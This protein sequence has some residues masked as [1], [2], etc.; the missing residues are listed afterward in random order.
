MEKDESLDFEQEQQFEEELDVDT[1]V[2][3]SSE[4]TEDQVDWKSEALKYKAILARHAKKSEAPVA[5]TADAPQAPQGLSRDEAILFAKG[6]EEKDIDYLNLIAKGKGVSIK[7][8]QEDELFQAYIQKQ[9]SEKKSA[10]AKLRASNSSGYAK[11]Q[12]GVTPGMTEAE[13]QAF[14]KKQTGA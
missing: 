5:R 10:Q 2:D 11:P 7:E 6:F 12:E 9:Q 3:T 1:S 13:H 8:A 14:W 4:Q